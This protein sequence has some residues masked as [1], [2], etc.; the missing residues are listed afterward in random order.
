MGVVGELGEWVEWG[1]EVGRV[2]DWELGGVLRSRVVGC[3]GSGTSVSGASG[4]E[5]VVGCG[6]GLGGDW[7]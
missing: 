7:G 6:W 2:G 1:V 5:G 4:G 3:W